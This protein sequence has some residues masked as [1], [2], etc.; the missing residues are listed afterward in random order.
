MA[1]TMQSVAGDSPSKTRAFFESPITYTFDVEANETAVLAVNI[2][3]T[4]LGPTINGG[5]P[6]RLFVE[7]SFDNEL[8]WEPVPEDTPV[9]ITAPGTYTW[10]RSQ[11]DSSVIGPIVRATVRPLSNGSGSWGDVSRCLRSKLDPTDVVFAP[12]AVDIGT[13]SSSTGFLNDGVQTPV[14]ADSSDPANNRPMPAQIMDGVNGAL[15]RAPNGALFT[16]Q[17][18][19]LGSDTTTWE[20]P[21][22]TEDVIRFRTGGV[23]G[24]IVQSMRITYTDATKEVIASTEEF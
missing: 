19:P 15:V 2:A 3:V 12:A 1:Y 21:S 10:K 11:D 16:E 6:L 14:E 17:K 7:S 24:A 5:N 4:D 23:A 22:A 8:S 18:M 13:I 20:Y 9:N